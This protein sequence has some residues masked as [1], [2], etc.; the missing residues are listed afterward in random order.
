MLAGTVVVET[1]FGL[2]GVGSVLVD[3]IN[4]HDFPVVQAVLLFMVVAYMT[5][6]IVVDVLY[7][8][9]DPRTRERSEAA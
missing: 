3:S 2:S 6:T 5:V 4:A 9:I 1:V 8:L 7:P